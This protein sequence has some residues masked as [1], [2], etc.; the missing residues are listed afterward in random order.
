[1]SV[2]RGLESGC[3]GGLLQLGSGAAAGLMS[4]V[5]PVPEV[6]V[7]LS[8]EGLE[9]GCGGG[10]LQLVQSGLQLGLGE[11]GQIGHRLKARPGQVRS[12]QG[13]GH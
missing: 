11:P 6:S 1:M 3:S 13:R 4:G 2:C 5:C 10:L 12:G 8:A 9:S 7:C